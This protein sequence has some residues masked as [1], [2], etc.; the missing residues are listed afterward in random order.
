MVPPYPV[1][2]GG[3]GIRQKQKKKK[4]QLGKLNQFIK[5]KNMRYPGITVSLVILIFTFMPSVGQ[6]APTYSQYIMNG[7]LL[8]PSL[9]GRDGYTTV[10]L[11]VREQWVGMKGAPSTFAASFQTRLVKRSY[12]DKS[13]SARIKSSMATKTG[14]VG[15]GGYVF[16]VNNG[17]MRRTGIQAT[18]A[19]HVSTGRS[20]LESP[21]DLAFG[22]AINAYQYAVNTD[23]FLYSYDDDLYLNTYDKSVFIPDFNFGAS[24]TKSDYYVGFAMT[25][26]FRGSLLFKNSSNTKRVEQGNYFLTGGVKFDMSK[27]WTIEPSAFIKSSDISFKTL[28]ADLTSRIYYRNDYWA[29]LSYRT[30]DALIVMTGIKY[31]IFY[32]A[33]AFDVTLTDIKKQSMGTHEFTLALKFG[34]SARRYSWINSY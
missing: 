9:T 3:L 32:F 31:D 17:I 28:Q 16:N 1:G 27:E 29:G 26:L 18:Y 19:Y 8:N 20:N 22:L 6:Q 11:T 13:V 15:I 23:G 2:K 21:G 12:I 4:W 33:Y 10:N 25:N 30:N 34:A 7:F 14:K 24:F 5:N